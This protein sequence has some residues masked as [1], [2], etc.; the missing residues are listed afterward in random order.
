VDGGPDVSDH[1]SIPPAVG[2][3]GRRLT[4]EEYDAHYASGSGGHEL[5]PE[6]LE[7][8]SGHDDPEAVPPS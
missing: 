4:D 3:P 7:T 2:D 8:L 5:P 6:V 1:S